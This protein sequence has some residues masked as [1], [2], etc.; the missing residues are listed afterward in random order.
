MSDDSCYDLMTEPAEGD[1]TL[2]TPDRTRTDT[3]GVRPSDQETQPMVQHDAASRGARR[4][5]RAALLVLALVAACG[6][7]VVADMRGTAT[8]VGGDALPAVATQ[9]TVGRVAGEIMK[10]KPHTSSTVAQPTTTEPGKSV[11]ATPPKDLTFPDTSAPNTDAQALRRRRTSGSTSTTVDSTTTTSKPVAPTT[12]ATAPTSAPT[13]VLVSVLDH[14]AIP[15]DGS[16]DQVA[17]QDAIDSAPAGATVVFPAGTYHHSDLFNVR[18]AG[19]TLWGYGATLVATNPN[20]HAI[21]LQA[22]NTS[23]L[24]FTLVGSPTVRLSAEEQMGIALHFTDGSQV[25]DN[26]VRGTSSAGIFIWGASNYAVLNNI[27]ENTMSD[28]IH[29]VGGANHGLVEGNTL[30]NV[31]D[32]CFAVV[33]YIQERRMTNHIT[34]RNNSCVGGHARG[35]SVV[36]G[37][38]VLIEGNT[39]EASGAA[40]IYLASEPSYDTYAAKRVRVIAN[41]LRGV[42]TNAAVRHGAIFLWGRAGSATTEDGTSY[43]LQNEDILIQGNTITDTAV[44]AA[45]LVAQGTYSYRVNFIGNATSGSRQHSYIELADGQYN[46][47]DDTHNGSP[48]SKHIGDASILP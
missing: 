10:K 8:P 11:G 3:V 36:G 33:S 27:V 6:E 46:M 47:V 42:N 5:R 16:D 48:V 18:T 25:R 37:T 39:I 7:P 38:D 17:I 12:T 30:R 26:T 31:G 24:G 9:D 20:R 13:G 35:V 32:D 2:L 45:H 22:N 23:V 4:S 40:G 29:S 14:G 41:T 43:T 15:N 1:T 21:I 34:I 28:G 44:G 19:V